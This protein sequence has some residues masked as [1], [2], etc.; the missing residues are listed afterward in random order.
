MSINAEAPFDFEANSTTRKT[1]ATIGWSLCADVVSFRTARK[2][3]NMADSI[4]LPLARFDLI[5][6]FF[7][8]IDLNRLDH[9]EIKKF[10][11][12]NMESCTPHAHTPINLFYPPNMATMHVLLTINTLLTTSLSAII[13]YIVT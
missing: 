3:Q 5:I 13:N 7:T 9:R 8:D 12:Y 1:L 11:R 6:F 10:I 2:K 4:S